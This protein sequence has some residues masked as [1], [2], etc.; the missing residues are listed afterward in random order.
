M[1]LSIFS[2]S[3]SDL[4]NALS[5]QA[6]THASAAASQRKIDADAVQSIALR[7]DIEQLQSQVENLAVYQTHLTNLIESQQ[8]EMAS[9]EAQITDT[10]HTRQGVVPLM[11]QMIEGL[12]QEV[13]QGLPIKIEQRQARVKKLADMMS[14]ADVSEAE[15]YRLILEAYQI[16][17][18]YG[19]KLSVYQGKLSIDGQVREADMLHLGKLSLVARSLDKS[20]Y[21]GFNGKTGQWQRLDHQFNTPIDTAFS[22]AEKQIAPSMLSLPLSAPVDP[23]VRHRDIA[24]S[25]MKESHQ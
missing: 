15:K 18:D 16:E 4:D 13:N 8:T 7:N 24:N 22:V 2:A 25:A 3:A 23:I 14:R 17:L 11:Y 6:Q 1:M 20:T 21:W 5:T 9:F 12:W 10:Q 19:T